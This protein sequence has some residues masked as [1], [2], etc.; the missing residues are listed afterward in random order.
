MAVKYILDV[1]IPPKQALIDLI[2]RDNNTTY[3]VDQLNVDEVIT[4]DGT[5]NTQI[6][7]SAAGTNPNTGS[8]ILTYDRIY[9]PDL[10]PE[11]LSIVY[12][13]TFRRYADLLPFVNNHYGINL[14][15]S[16][17]IDQNV[18][19][20]PVEGILEFTLH[21]T[22]EHH[23]L[24][25]RCEIKLM[26]A[27]A[28]NEL[29]LKHTSLV[30]ADY[31]VKFDYKLNNEVFLTSA[32]DNTVLNNQRLYLKELSPLPTLNST[33]V[34]TLIVSGDTSGINAQS[35]TLTTVTGDP[36]GLS[37][38]SVA[39]ID[40]ATYQSL[41]FEIVTTQMVPGDWI[42]QF[43]FKLHN[44]EIEG[45]R[46][47]VGDKY[48]DL[49]TPSYAYSSTIT[50]VD[51]ISTA[52]T[53]QNARNNNHLFTS[54]DGQLPRSSSM[55]NDISSPGFQIEPV[56]N[57][58]FEPTGVYQ[59]DITELVDIVRPY[60]GI[61]NNSGDSYSVLPIDSP[62]YIELETWVDSNPIV[63]PD[64]LGE[65]L[66][67]LPIYDN[68]QS[69]D[70]QILYYS[71]VVDVLLKSSTGNVYDFS[72]FN[73]TYAVKVPLITFNEAQGYIG[74]SKDNTLFT[75]PSINVAIT[76]ASD[77]RM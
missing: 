22:G 48:V 17:I 55:Y 38:Y 42:C 36:I 62:L 74:W 75:V 76:V 35:A 72:E 68:V 41:G 24:Y 60:V 25:G 10:N 47:N 71:S 44:P 33:G 2:N 15:A 30:D 23:T 66:S 37:P 14:T 8:A 16:E 49:M 73:G 77:F 70:R 65:A 46:I 34:H 59:P 12:Q 58:R 43:T 27:T 56:T 3:T 19:Q 67:K 50:S 52:A 51:E 32:L 7:V 4:N 54:Y 45:I 6:I 21:L 18:L 57:Y 1:N 64:G 28:S 31:Y 29:L 53:Y 63:A 13:D 26:A 9:L 5:R 11:P 69:P 20:M 40:Y 61:T 39:M